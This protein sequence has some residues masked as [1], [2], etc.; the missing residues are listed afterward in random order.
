MAK[1]IDAAVVARIRADLAA[2]RRL[3][4]PEL[5]FLDRLWALERTVDAILAAIE[6]AR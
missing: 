5:T 1:L 6:A 2:A 4:Q 3:D